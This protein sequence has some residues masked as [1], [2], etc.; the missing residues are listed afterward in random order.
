MLPQHC[1]SK[2]VTWP[3]GLSVSPDRLILCVTVHYNALPPHSHVDAELGLFRFSSLPATHLLSPDV[4]KHHWHKHL[5]EF[6][7]QGQR[8]FFLHLCSS[9]LTG[10]SQGM[11]RQW[12]FGGDGQSQRNQTTLGDCRQQVCDA[13]SLFCLQCDT[14]PGCLDALDKVVWL[15]NEPAFHDRSNVLGFQSLD[16]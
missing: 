6:L 1:K 12:L 2:R 9:A 5:K 16:C 4:W 14:E 10:A 11:N 15:R 8:M 3:C 7:W 13:G